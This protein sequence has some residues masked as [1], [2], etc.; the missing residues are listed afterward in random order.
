MR[1]S[2]RRPRG[3]CGGQSARRGGERAKLCLDRGCFQPGRPSSAKISPVVAIARGPIRPNA[4]RARPYS[5]P[6]VRGPNTHSQNPA[7]S[8]E[9]PKLAENSPSSTGP[10]KYRSKL[11]W[12][13]EAK[14]PL[15]KIWATGPGW[16]ELSKRRSDGPRTGEVSRTH[17]GTKGRACGGAS[18]P[19][20]SDG[21]AT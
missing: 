1:A 14:R 17:Q 6:L 8:Y 19:Q 13:P 7:A 3:C 11:A 2:G 18:R 4:M 10:V 16:K 9:S 21:Q 20:H 12:M 5:A 15:V